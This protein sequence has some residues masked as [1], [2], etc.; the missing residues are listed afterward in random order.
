M[1]QGQWIRIGEETGW[2]RVSAKKVNLEELA[3]DIYQD[4]LGDAYWDDVYKEYPDHNNTQADDSTC[5]ILKFLLE[6]HKDR[7][8][9]LNAVEYTEITK[10]LRSSILD[11]LT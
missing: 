5:Y 7:F 8:S 10:M 11:G 3:E 4:S 2:M 9:D 6:K 1:T